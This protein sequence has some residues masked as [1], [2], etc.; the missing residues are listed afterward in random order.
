VLEGIDGRI[1][2]AREFGVD[3][4]IDFREYDTVDARADRVRELTDGVGADVGVEVAGVPDAFSEGIHLLRDGGRYLEIGNVSPGQM[5]DFDPGSL[6]RKALTI[7]SAVRYQPWY[8]KRALRFLEENVDKYPYEDLIDAHFNL[9][10]VDE[11]LAE[12]DSRDVTR[13]ALNPVSSD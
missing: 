2:R 3:H 10:D 13:A 9:E 5:T 11:A 4:V 6:T 8:L 7:E 1:D 12:S